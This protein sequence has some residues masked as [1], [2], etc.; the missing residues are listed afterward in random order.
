MVN[1]S[2]V[3]FKSFADQKY[4]HPRTLSYD[5]HVLTILDLAHQGCGKK[6][7]S[8]S[9]RTMPS[10]SSRPSCYRYLRV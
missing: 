7:K 1:I 5:F 10:P 4:V 2:E 6:S 9:N 3:Q 8:S